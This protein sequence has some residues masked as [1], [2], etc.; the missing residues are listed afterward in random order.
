MSCDSWGE[1]CGEDGVGEYTAN[2]A[3]AKPT[4][5]FA[6]LLD[7]VPMATLGKWVSTGLSIDTISHAE[8]SALQS[9]CF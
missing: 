7:V 6:T 3:P 8:P 2:G 1:G 5:V 4:L 9:S